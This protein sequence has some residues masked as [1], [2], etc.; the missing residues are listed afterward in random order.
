MNDRVHRIKGGA[1]G[2]AVW[3]A[4][5]L[6]LLLALPWAARGRLPQPLATHWGGEVPDGSM[7]LWA[8]ALFPGLIWVLLLLAALVVHRRGATP[9]RAWAGA[10]LAFGGTLLTGAQAS[11]VHANLDRPSWRDAAPVDAAVVLVLGA[12]TAAGLLGHLAGRRG[13]AR[14]SPRT[15]ADGPTIDVPAGERM[16]W[17]SRT[18][19]PWL[20]LLSAVLGLAAAAAALASAGGLIG[21]PWALAA[22]FAVTSVVVLG[23]SSVQTRVTAD[24]LDVA[25]GPLGWPVRHWPLD[26]VD[27]ARAE[28]RAPAQ[29]GGW[30]YRL[31][32]RGTT[33]MLRRGECLVVRSRK[34][35]EF[36]VSV[37]D[38]ERGAALL[39]SL[40]ARRN[41]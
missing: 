4:G 23:C 11:I 33:V 20:S 13:G 29:V 34:G 14:P 24:G 37:D 12:A 38:A 39:N 41:T 21:A 8:A 1:W 6:I 36:A 25:F 5:V 31:S 26:D 28:D 30:G 17:L 3:S 10:A 27:S 15:P 32:G 35:A 40:T 19:N 2:A 16:V 22:P 18:A 9:A 7:P